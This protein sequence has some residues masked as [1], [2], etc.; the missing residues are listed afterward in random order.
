M[1]PVQRVE[2]DAEPFENVDAL[3][4][5]FQVVLEAA[6]NRGEAEVEEVAQDAPGAPARSGRSVPS[7]AGTRQVM[8]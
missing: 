7:S 8:L 3:A 1:R 4:Q 2:D 6:A 5:F